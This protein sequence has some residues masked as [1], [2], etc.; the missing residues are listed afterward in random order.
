[1][2]TINSIISKV[3][4]GLDERKRNVLTKRFGLE[5]TDQKEVTIPIT[6]EQ[7]ESTPLEILPTAGGE[8]E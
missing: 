4:K 5:G 1:M 8:N 3:L 6:T 2:A 7:G